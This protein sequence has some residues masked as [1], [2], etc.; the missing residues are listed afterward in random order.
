MISQMH[1]SHSLNNVSSLCVYIFVLYFT[2]KFLKLC[3]S[4]CP[5]GRTT[6][7]ASCVS[8]TLNTITDTKSNYSSLGSSGH[9]PIAVTCFSSLS[10]IGTVC[11]LSASHARVSLTTI[12]PASSVLTWRSISY[13]TA[14]ATARTLPMFFTSLR[15]PN[16]SPSR[17]T[18]TLAS[19][20]KAP[21]TRKCSHSLAV[22]QGHYCI[23]PISFITSSSLA[24]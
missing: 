23:W 7:R 2:T 8:H 16:G 14:C 10:R 21:S 12:P 5:V 18:D 24:Y 1:K 4:F 13:S 20:L 17:W 3:S 9:T 11:L 19:T 22:A 15:T 6:S